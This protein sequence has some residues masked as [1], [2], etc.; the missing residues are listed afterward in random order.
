MFEYLMPLLVM[1][2]YANT[3][4]DE[5]YS[6]AIRSQI[7]YG[8]QKE[9]PW[10]FS[11]SCFN[12]LDRNQDR[13][14][15][16]PYVMAADVYAV[17]PNEGRG[18]WSWYTGAAG[19][20]YRAGLENILGF[21]KNGHTLLIDPCIPAKWL[22]FRIKY[23]YMDTCYTIAVQNPE[24]RQQGVWETTL[25]GQRMAGNTLPLVNDGTVHEVNVVLG[26]RA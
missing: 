17:T 21:Q 14:K 18:G 2:S 6:F 24:G 3:L 25:D 4:L 5:S 20:M 13:Y 7:K 11:E 15:V 26:E 12:A 1:K 19:W 22:G 16:E 23:Q 10:G 8:R 9:M